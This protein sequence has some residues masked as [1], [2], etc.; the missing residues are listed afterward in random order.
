M[1]LVYKPVAIIIDDFTTKSLVY[2]NVSLYDAGYTSTSDLTLSYLESSDYSEWISHNPS[3]DTV[4]QHGDWVLDAYLSQ[5]D[6]DVEVILIDF[7]TI[8]S[9]SKYDS[10][11][12]D[13]LFPSIDDIIDDWTFKNNTDSIN[14]FPSVVSA[15]FGNG[16]STLDLNL[17]TALLSLMGTYTVIVQSIP[18]VGVDKGD[19]FSW[20]DSLADVISVGAYNLDSNSYALF[21]SPANPAVIDILADGYIENP[22]WVDESNKGWNF[23][24][25]FATPRVSA[26]ITNLWVDI[27]DDIDFSNKISYSDFVD[28]ILADISTDIYI[29]T[30]NSG[31]LSAPVP[32]LSDGLTL[33]LEDVKVAYNNGDSDFHVLEAA[34]SIPTNSTPKVLTTI[35]DAHVDNGIAYS[36]DISSHFIDTDGD[37]LTYS[38]VIVNNDNT[39]SALSTTSWLSI[40]ESTGILSGT[41]PDS[42]G[43]INVKVSAKDSSNKSV[44]DTYTL[45]IGFEEFQT[46]TTALN[47]QRDPDITT[48]DDG[49][50]VVTWYGY[51]YD[52]FNS[53]V[54]AQRFDTAGNKIGAEIQINTYTQDAQRKPSISSLNDGG[55]IV[56]WESWAQDGDDWGIYVQRFDASSNPVG[57]ETQVNTYTQGGQGGISTAGLSNGGYIVTW[58]SYEQDGDDLGIYAQRFDANSDKVGN[59][60][61][62]NTYITGYQSRSD[63][64]ALLDGGYVITWRSYQQDG[65]ASGIYAQRYDVNGI[66]VGNEFL[67]NTVTESTQNF[68]SIAALTDGGYVITWHSKYQDGSYYGIYGQRYDVNGK[69]LGSGQVNTYTLNSQSDPSITSLNDG[70]FIVTWE[71]WAQDGD[72]WGIYAQRF[73]AN[74]DKMGNEFLVNRITDERQDNPVISSLNDGGFVISWVSDAQDGS[75][76]GIFTQRYDANSQPLDG[77]NNTYNLIN[78]SLATEDV[79]YTFDASTDF[80]ALNPNSIVSYS[81]S[82]VDGSNLPSWLSFDS[83]TGEFSGTPSNDDTGLISVTVVATN[84]TGG[85]LYDTFYLT[86]NNVN[87]APTLTGDFNGSLI[88]GESVVTGSLLGD[89]VD[90]YQE[91]WH[92]SNWTARV[93][94]TDSSDR[95]VNT[96][97]NTSGD[98]YVYTF[99]EDED[100][101]SVATYDYT[102]SNGDWYYQV[103]TTQ[104]NGDYTRHSTS[105]L[106]K[107]A[108]KTYTYNEDGSRDMSS[109]GV[110]SSQGVLHYIVS[111]SSTED[112]SGVVTSSAGVSYLDGRLFTTTMVG[113]EDNGDAIKV[114]TAS[115]D[116]GIDYVIRVN[117]GLTYTIENQQGVYGSIALDE[118]VNWTYTLDYTDPDT[119]AIPLTSSQIATD[120]F[121]IT[122]FDG[123]DNITQKIDIAIDNTMVDVDA[124]DAIVL[125]DSTPHGLHNTSVNLWNDGVDTLKSITVDNGKVLINSDVSFD[126]VKLSAT[127]AFDFD[128]AIDIGDAID[129]LRHIVKLEEF[130]AGSAE[131][132]AADTDNSGSIEIGDAIDI[133]RHIVK[134]EE[135]DSF[136][137]IDTTGTRVTKLDANVTGTASAWTLVANGDVDLSGSFDAAY[138]V[139]SDLI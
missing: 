5:L 41:V 39:E 67:V 31:W 106:G 92:A 62:V 51:K 50:F 82:L 4:V 20:G 42:I 74:S 84:N 47:R 75:G 43:S 107:D 135:I 136:D 21:G 120:S 110:W 7:D 58:E 48:L 89:D 44:S 25:S 64:T 26:E 113:V 36:N 69:A 85:D 100:T 79:P 63:V 138:T 3:D 139:T 71:S 95:S 66:K 13:L 126:E 68:P 119:I 105:S 16:E 101:S 118:Q 53:E 52:G 123:I 131:F 72:H 73:D 19:N 24:T 83:S 129:V 76:Y 28:S 121:T 104:I 33:S 57:T 117:E 93:Y 10:T 49:S 114:R 70:G 78:D 22:E 125:T 80:V 2:D 112:S 133:L 103:K 86:V 111:S 137:L 109:S 115:T 55:F 116:L 14:Y 77:S 32:I 1:P 94:S 38:A 56:T 102:L 45:A 124:V 15:S 98:S 27:L 35:A 8:P 130:T 127:D 9:T 17:S 61:L 134:L 6:S 87:D 18:N 128:K 132:H 54:F 60:F 96:R 37:V 29:E 34:Y 11:Q 81:A 122:V 108:T 23:G 91:I 97:T 99:L 65:D 30:A 90:E 59:E 40:D 88:K 12:Y 46:N